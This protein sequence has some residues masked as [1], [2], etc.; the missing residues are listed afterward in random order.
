MFNP[1][2][3]SRLGVD[4]A[5]PDS[6][7]QARVI[8]DV[9]P[10]HERN[11]ETMAKHIA[12]GYVSEPA[13]AMTEARAQELAKAAKLKQRITAYLEKCRA[14][15]NAECFKCGAISGFPGVTLRRYEIGPKQKGYMCTGCGG[16]NA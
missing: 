8:V 9:R 15:G 3:R 11:A 10:E 1:F 2:K 13:P 12:Q 16:K 4:Q 14:Q 7:S 5:K 6:E